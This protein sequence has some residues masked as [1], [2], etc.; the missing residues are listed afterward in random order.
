LTASSKPACGVSVFN[1]ESQ[2]PV[3]WEP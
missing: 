3:I 2:T 1:D